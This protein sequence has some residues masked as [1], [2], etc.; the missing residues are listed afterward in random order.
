MNELL[1]VDVLVV[2][3]GPAGASAAAHAARGGLSV[4]AVERKREIGLPVQCAEWV[5]LTLGRHAQ[6]EGVLQQRIAGMYSNLPSGRR[7]H[8]EFP[9]LMVDRAAFDQALATE[10]RRCG[11]EIRCSTRLVTLDARRCRAKLR[12]DA[13]EFELE[14]GLLI[15]ADGPRSSVARALGLQMLASAHTRQYTVPLRVPS[16]QTEVWLADEYPGGYAWLFPKGAWA[17]LGVGLEGRAP[18]ELKPALDALHRRLVSAGRVGPDIVSA[19]GGPIPIDAL[20]EKLVV[21]RTLFVGDAAGLANPITG[22]GIA[23]A[24]T[25]GARAGEA[26]AAWVQGAGEGALGAFEEDLRDQFEAPLLRAKER[27]RQLALCAG[28]AAGASEAAYRRGWVA[29]PEYFESINE[30][31][32]P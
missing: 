21:G 27:R 13:T 24:V 1:R 18:Q 26:A 23:A 7:E 16:K 15:A 11:A 5:P 9:G 12:N 28:G 17:N 31:C 2:G 30:G 6:G 14:Y 8:S 29:F 19:T 3:L 22:A 20:R 32:A 25:S 4:L 10:A